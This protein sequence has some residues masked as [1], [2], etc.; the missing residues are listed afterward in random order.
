VEETAPAARRKL[1]AANNGKFTDAK[2][3]KQD[4]K[5]TRGLTPKEKA[6]Y[7]RIDEASHKKKR[8]TTMKQDII[9]DKKI[10]AQIK[11]KRKK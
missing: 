8:P 3:K 9:K 2:N 10:V 6:E 4:A 7:K 11:A 5:L 1:M